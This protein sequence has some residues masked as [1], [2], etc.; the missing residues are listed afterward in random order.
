MFKSG[1]PLFN[2]S[3]QLVEHGRICSL[4]CFD[5]LNNLGLVQFRAPCSIQGSLVPDCSIN[6][7]Q[8]IE[9]AHEIKNN[10]V[11]KGALVFTRAPVHTGPLCI[12]VLSHSGELV[13]LLSGELVS[14]FSGAGL[15][16]FRRAGLV[17]YRTCESHFFRNIWNYIHITSSDAF[18]VP[19]ILSPSFVPN[20]RPH[21]CQAQDV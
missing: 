6:K 16:I 7:K 14:L 18:S 9:Q 19:S 10:N 20:L 15:L 4:S 8:D 3:K 21:A 2:R 12:Q 13:Y 5:I 17:V 1:P 11:N